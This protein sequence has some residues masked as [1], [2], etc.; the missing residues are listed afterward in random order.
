MSVNVRWYGNNL[1]QVIKYLL[2]NLINN[3]NKKFLVFHWTPSEIIDTSIE[4]ESITMPECN[5]YKINSNSFSNCRYDSIPMLKLGSNL[6]KNVKFIE[7]STVAVEFESNDTKSLLMT[8]EDK[9]N[10]M[11]D[12]NFL[13]EYSVKNLSAVY[14]EI[15]C[16]WMKKN[17]DVVE[18]WAPVG[19]FVWNEIIIGAM[20]PSNGS[21]KVYNGISTAAKMA[22]EA[23]NNDENILKYYNLTV[24]IMNDTCR[25]AETLRTFINFYNIDSRSKNVIGIVG[26]TCSETVEPIAG[27]SKYFRMPVIAYS[28]EGSDFRNRELYPYLFRTIGENRQYVEIYL[29]LFKTMN[30]NRI[31]TLTEDGQ[32]YSEY[33]SD[34][35]TSLQEDGIKLLVNKKFP[36]SMSENLIIAVSILF[37]NSYSYTIRNVVSRRETIYFQYL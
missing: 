31:G 6:V 19:T 2:K 1:Q 32:K 18:K 24:L 9:M 14:N 11:F 29:K 10:K 7:V 13:Q 15:A 35:D 8:Y 34:M 33:L 21:S 26:P 17:M 28:A 23:I 36:R 16:E 22:E 3:R 12:T 4:Y 27:L 5:S 37:L 20:F 25:P 30:W